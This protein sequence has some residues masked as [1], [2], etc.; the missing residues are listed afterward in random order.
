MPR[1]WW[2][3]HQQT[4]RQEIEGQYLWSPK[5]NANGSRKAPADWRTHSFRPEQKPYFPYHRR[6]VF[7][8]ET[9]L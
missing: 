3:N 4:W 5:L 1:Y 8:S 7:L 9:R 6:E 2:V